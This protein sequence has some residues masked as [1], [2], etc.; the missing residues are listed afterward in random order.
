M[1][2]VGIFLSVLSIIFGLRMI[3]TAL[4]AVLTGKVLVRQGIRTKWQSAPDMSDVWKL[5]FRD[6]LMGV[7]L[8]ILGIMLIL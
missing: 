5:A 6:A 1:R 2:I 7:L 3:I 4:Q 8:I